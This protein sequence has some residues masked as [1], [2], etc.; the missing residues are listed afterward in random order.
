[1]E[2][3]ASCRPASA[4]G[5]RCRIDDWTSIDIVTRQ[6][7]LCGVAPG[8]SCLVVVDPTSHPQMGQIAALAASRLGADTVTVA[9]PV[10]ITSCSVGGLVSSI[11]ASGDV[12][13]DLTADGACAAL[14]LSADAR[15]LIAGDLSPER[16]RRLHPHVGLSRRVERA[17][18]RIS[19]ASSLELQSSDGSSL[20][21]GLAGATVEG[22]GGVPTDATPVA[23]WPDGRVTVEPAEGAVEGT[24]VAMPRDVLLQ[25]H[26]YVSSPVTLPIRNDHIA[27]VSGDSGDADL[28]R[29]LLGAANHRDA[30]GFSQISL[31]L[32]NE[33]GLRAGGH[34]TS[35]YLRVGDAP[36][37][38]GVVTVAFGTNTT[39]GRTAANRISLVLHGHSVSVDGR[40]LIA[41]GHLQGD[42]RP[43]VYESAG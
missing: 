40:P 4:G 22:H 21:I 30:Y 5:Y 29:A 41:A 3:D 33:S 1:M 17:V 32:A 36:R 10:P 38:A 35:P 11:G 7:D 28:L 42:L 39:A 18:E 26:A 23:R 2:I 37:L 25:A 16:L 43:D 9:S 6:L 24:V 14:P 34:A 8:V 27:D 12:V 31:G 19:Q 15:V 13:V 20:I